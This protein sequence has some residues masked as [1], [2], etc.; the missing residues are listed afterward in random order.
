MHL[1]GVNR[2]T[3]DYSYSC[4]VDIVLG[5]YYYRGLSS[6]LERNRGEV[7]GCSSCDNPS[8]SAVASVEY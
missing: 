8:D 4:K 5:V 3:T 6:E 7:F 1:S 2:L